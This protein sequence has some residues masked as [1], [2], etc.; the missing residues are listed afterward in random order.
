MYGG[1]YSK[2]AAKALHPERTVFENENAPRLNGSVFI[3]SNY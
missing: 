1:I 2:D 3:I